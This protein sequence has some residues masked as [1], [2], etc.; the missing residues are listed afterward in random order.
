MSPPTHNHH[1]DKP[2]HIA[3]VR[4][5]AKGADAI[6]AEGPDLVQAGEHNY[7]VVSTKKG[8]AGHPAAWRNSEIEYYEH[9]LDLGAR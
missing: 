7:S 6:A 3:I 8:F 4:P 9:D 2:G 1:D 5:S